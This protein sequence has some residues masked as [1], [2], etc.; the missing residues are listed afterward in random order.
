[1]PRISPIPATPFHTVT[2]TDPALELSGLAEKYPD[3]EAAVVRVVVHPSPAGP[4]CRDFSEIS[5][6]S[7]DGRR[8]QVG[9][10]PRHGL[11]GQIYKGRHHAS[12]S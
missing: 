12:R 10:R 5:A 9:V 2:L 7:R 11:T 6:A 8:G 4:A 3:R 1:M